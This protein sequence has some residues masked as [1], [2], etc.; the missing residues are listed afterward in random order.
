MI[1]VFNMTSSAIRLYVNHGQVQAPDK[2]VP[3][4]GF[5]AFPKTIGLQRRAEPQVF[6][7]GDNTVALDY[8]DFLPPMPSGAE[9]SPNIPDAVLSDFILYL[10]G[11][12]ALLMRTSGQQIER[13]NWPL[14]PP[15]ATDAPFSTTQKE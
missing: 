11:N 6:G 15:V 8:R 3:S 1:I 13:Y 9:F 5:K 14:V 10:F 7:I 2:I 12:G 4:T